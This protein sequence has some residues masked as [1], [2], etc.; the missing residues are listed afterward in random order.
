MKKLL[1]ATIITSFLLLSTGIPT[2]A[3]DVSS[4]IA[5]ELRIADEAADDG[6]IVVTT[7][8]GY[9]LSS[10][11]YQSNM[12]GVVSDNPAVSFLSATGGQP[13]ISSGNAYVKISTVNGEIAEGDFITSSEIPGVGMR[14]DE[15][16]F[17]LG[18]ALEEFTADS[19]DEIGKI[20]VSINIRS[21]IVDRD[22]RGNLL[23]LLRQGAAAPVL[24]PLTT[25]RYLLA[26]AVAAGAFVIGF[27]FFGKVARSGVEALGRNP[28]A[29]KL[30]ELSV[31]FNV[32]L[33]IG[34][35]L[36]GLGIAFLI[37]V[38]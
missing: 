32:V 34:I 35:M 11:T 19:P 9:F 14:A 6:S 28:L 15:N 37:L 25:F 24:T 13:V 21:N 18:T 30:I 1:K 7:D 27:I 38:L 23:E 20:L 33:T 4:G 29:G 16:G 26:G 2:Y 31:V 22:V 17:V 36:S 3:Q 10:E 5:I 12:F 8:T